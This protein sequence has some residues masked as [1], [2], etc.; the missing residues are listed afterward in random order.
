MARLNG[1]EHREF[2]RTLLVCLK[3]I[4]RI[5]ESIDTIL[6]EV[7]GEKCRNYFE[8]QAHISNIHKD[9]K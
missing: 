6:L 3:N 8:M 1:G 9:L 5:S 4:N 2:G 7:C